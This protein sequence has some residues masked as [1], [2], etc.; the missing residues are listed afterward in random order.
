MLAKLGAIL[1]H[2]GRE[3]LVAHGLLEAIQITELL[4]YPVV[5]KPIRRAKG[6][7]V[8]LD[9][10]NIGDLMQA[11][12]HA[13]SVS[14]AFVVERHIKGATWRIIVSNGKFVGLLRSKPSLPGQVKA[15][16]SIT[17]LA[18]R[19]A[20]QLQTGLLVL[21][22]VTADISKPL[23]VTGGAVVDLDL[24]PELGGFL[25]PNSTLWKPVMDGFIQSLY[26]PGA[27]S[28]IPIIAVTGTSAA[29]TSRMI[30]LIML[31][32]GLDS[33][34]SCAEGLF[35]DGKRIKRN[36]NPKRPREMHHRLM[37]N[38]KI[39]LAIMEFSFKQLQLGGFPFDW[40]NIGVF[41]HVS[42]EEVQPGWE[43]PRQIAET[44]RAVLERSREG[45][46]LSADDSHTPGMLQH[47]G[48]RRII[49]TSTCQSASAIRSGSSAVSG[50]VTIERGQAGDRIMIS[51]ETRKLDLMGVTEI[52]ATFRE[53]TEPTLEYALQAIAVGHLMKIPH[54]VIRAAMS[55][56]E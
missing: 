41:T 39:E 20:H 24:A 45:V 12:N 23:E 40:C 25:Q 42:A 35:L 13:Q 11:V 21:T 28:R 18:E 31:Q 48:A 17:E 14:K 33:A 46:V 22:V 32:A 37:R 53:A 9:V 16:A 51:E 47:L 34:L 19:V 15:A 36:R 10:R 26:P 43:T 50:L 29:I 3:P 4:R 7:G 1:P 8:T 52:S 30:D 56:S 38:R 49:L 2:D 6:G 44:L 27:A 55:S 54:A 5:L